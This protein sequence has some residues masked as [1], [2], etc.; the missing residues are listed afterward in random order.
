MM[1]DSNLDVSVPNARRPNTRLRPNV[2]CTSLSSMDDSKKALVLSDSELITRLAYWELLEFSRECPLRFGGNF[3]NGLN[4][5]QKLERDKYLDPGRYIRHLWPEES[6]IH[7]QPFPISEIDWPF[8]RESGLHG[9]RSSIVS[10]PA[11]L[12][13]EAI[14]TAQA[15]VPASSRIA[16]IAPDNGKKDGEPSDN[17]RDPQ[18]LVIDAPINFHQIVLAPPGTGKTFVLIRR[19]AHLIADGGVT[20]PFAEVLVLCFS[21]AAVAEIVRRLRIEATERHDNNLR[22]IQVRTFDSYATRAL[23]RGHND[24][25]LASGYEGRICQFSESLDSGALPEAARDELAALRFLVVDEVQD[26]VG[27]R[28]RMTLALIRFVRRQGGSILLCGDPAQAIY[29]WQLPEGDIFTSAEFLAQARAILTQDVD[30][31]SETPLTKYHRFE[32]A[33]LLSLVRRCR[34]AI[35]HDGSN[36]DLSQLTNEL[37]GIS[38]PME[39]LGDISAPTERIAVLTR[40]NLEAFQI[41]E[42]C[43][44]DGISH[45]VERG[46]TG[47]YWP[48]WLAR[49]CFGYKMD[50][51]PLTTARTRWELRVADRENVPFEMALTYLRQHGCAEGDFLDLVDLSRLVDKTQPES[52]WPPADGNTLTISTIHRSKGLEFDRVA[53]LQSEPGKFSGG[54]DDEGQGEARVLY[55]AATRARRQLI[56][57]LRDG[58]VLRRGN[59]F[60]KGFPWMKL[61]R[62]HLFDRQSNSNCVLIDGSEEFDLSDALQSATGITSEPVQQK[63]W[64][65]CKLPSTG[66][67][68]QRIESGFYWMLPCGTRLCQVARPLVNCL[69]TMGKCYRNSPEAACAIRDVPVVDCASISF[70]WEGGDEVEAR[71]GTSRLAMIPVLYGLGSVVLTD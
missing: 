25:R 32:D 57:L 15:E 31:F 68:A 51:M 50:R 29:D 5:R 9:I 13:A 58:T 19:L 48:A 38:L 24:A 61:P 41:S 35:G 45:R 11:V 20:N 47:R 39:R 27:D 70:A 6:P 36:P 49:L 63:I 42:M 21:R 65:L 55:V 67:S 69:N 43:R 26:L 59:K 37:R 64:E 22:H 23:T 44:R 54:D 18:E 7:F 52:C 16:T 4:D 2:I 10:A 56:R 40:T 1:P 28:A 8:S 60:C 53:L 14:R 66:L 17:G 71:L 33:E 3:R 46:S 12:E 62:F 30:R 34:T